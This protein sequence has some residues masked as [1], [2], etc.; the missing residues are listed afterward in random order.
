[1]PRTGHSPDR[2][3]VHTLRFRRATA[4]PSMGRIIRPSSPWSTGVGTE[5]ERV[6]VA[7]R[8]TREAVRVASRPTKSPVSAGAFALSEPGLISGLSRRMGW[9]AGERYP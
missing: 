5:R 3:R 1:M 8:L 2:E 6:R 7:G 9:T 4:A